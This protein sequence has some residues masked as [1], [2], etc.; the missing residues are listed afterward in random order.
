MGC[1]IEAEKGGGQKFLP[2]RSRIPRQAASF[3]GAGCPERV[4]WPLSCGVGCV[5]E[6]KRAAAKNSYRGVV[7]FHGKWLLP[8]G[9]V[10]KERVLACVLWR[11][12][13]AEKGT[14][15]KFLPRRTRI[16]RQTAS[17]KGLAAQSAC[18][19]RCPGAWGAL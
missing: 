3:Q 14:G 9:W 15:Q 7:G 11:G 4:P 19:G 6:A 12:I 17:F 13:G 2:Q 1:V 8:R 16:P 18:P 5:I 10:P